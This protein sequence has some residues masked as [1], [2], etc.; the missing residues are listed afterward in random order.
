MSTPNPLASAYLAKGTVGNVGLAGAPV[1]A[2]ALVVTPSTHKVSGSVH[3]SQSTQH[4]NYT[5]TVTG[6]IYSTGLGQFTQVVGLTGTL[7]S[8]S[9]TPLLIPIEINLAIDNAWNGTGGFQYANVH[10]ENAPVKHLDH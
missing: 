2:F 6:T 7:H 8:D 5:G 10:V 4:G 3:V 1:V 9:P